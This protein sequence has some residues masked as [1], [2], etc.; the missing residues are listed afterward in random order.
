MLAWIRVIIILVIC[1]MNG[2]ALYSQDNIDES[3]LCALTP[4]FY[5]DQKTKAVSLDLQ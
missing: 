2:R 5:Y 3:M 1:I 4:P